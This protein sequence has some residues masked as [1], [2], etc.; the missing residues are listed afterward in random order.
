MELTRND[1]LAVVVLEMSR[2][3]GR[4]ISLLTEEQKGKVAEILRSNPI[5]Q[6]DCAVELFLACVGELTAEE[7][8]E[9]EENLW[10]AIE[11]EDEGED[12]EDE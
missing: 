12:D 3:D 11:D 5:F 10:D 2:L 4:Y 8:G 7:E 1:L 9:E 6:V